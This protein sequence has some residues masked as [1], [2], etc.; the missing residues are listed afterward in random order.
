MVNGTTKYWYG[1]SWPCMV[2]SDM[3]RATSL[4][5]SG[6]ESS[7]VIFASSAAAKE[8]TRAS[9]ESRNGAIS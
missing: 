5:Q 7:A 2:D 4:T 3:P 1:S 6:A 8:A 9:A